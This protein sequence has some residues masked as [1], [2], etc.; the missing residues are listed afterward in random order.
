[1]RLLAPICAAALLPGTALAQAIRF[2]DATA[3]SGIDFLHDDGSRGSRYIMEN[4]ASGLGFIDFDSD[5]DL[6]LYL[7]NGAP[8]GGAGRPNALWRND[9]K[10][11]FS[12]ATASSGDAADTGYSMGCAVADYDNDGDEDIYL[13]S[14]GP[15]RLLRNDGKGGFE[16]VAAVA[17]VDHPGFGAGCSFLDYDRDGWL[18]IYLSNYLE[19]DPA[20]HRPCRIA[21]VPVYCDPRTY[22][23]QRDLLYRNRG[24]GTFEDA[25]LTSGVSGKAS[26]GMGTVCGDFDGDGWTDIFVGNDVQGNFLWSNQRDGTFRERALLAGVAYDEFGDPQGSMGVNAGDYDNDGVPDLLVTTY[27]NQSN[28]LYRGLGGGRFQDVTLATGIGSGSLPLVT[29]GCGMADFDADG[30]REV[31]VAAGHLQDTIEEYNGASTYRQRNQLYQWRSGRF[32]EI[33]DQAGPALRIAESSRGAVFGDVD[34]DGDVDLVVLNARARPTL[35]ENRTESPHHW[36]VLK[37]VGSRGSPSAVGARVRLKAGELVLV[38]EVRAGRGYQGADDLRLHF[39]LGG[40]GKIDELEIRWP[41]GA[42]EVRAG[43]EADRILRIVEGR[44]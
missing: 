36:T 7:L 42:V 3:E 28:T 9:G 30:R 24:D 16:D 40:H 27:Q 29:W 15:N 33:S 26:Y 35:L 43:L 39:G 21:G 41:G 32:R 8:A 13:T 37:L 18:D 34:N 31:F 44:P 14:Y 4:I 19:F 23:P 17:G 10:G 12:D 2:H 6:D 25:S 20:D 22:R 38:D 1:M 11:R 5:G